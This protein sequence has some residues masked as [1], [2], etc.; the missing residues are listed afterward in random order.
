[1]LAAAGDVWSD[2][3][4][5]VAGETAQAGH[6]QQV[7]GLHDGEILQDRVES[8]A[9]E[10][11][12][13][14]LDRIYQLQP[15]QQNVVALI[16]ASLTSG[17]S[18]DATVLLRTAIDQTQFPDLDDDEQFMEDLGQLVLDIRDGD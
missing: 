3:M 8:S 1:M 14:V 2:I 13:R 11:R 12:S 10:I 5:L 15:E 6:D 4:P 17:S 9:V 18:R 7:K 16:V